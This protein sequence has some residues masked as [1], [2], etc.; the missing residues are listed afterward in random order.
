MGTTYHITYFDKHQRNFKDNIDSLLRVVNHAINTYDSAS[1][2]SQF[3][4]SPRGIALKDIH[5]R[6]ILRAAVSVF[7]LSSGAFDPTVMPLV[8][9]WGF[10][11][12][13]SRTPNQAMIDSLRNFVGMEK[14]RITP[15]SLLKTDPRVQLD[16]GGI[17]QGYGADVITAFLKAKGIDNMLVELGG[18]GMVHGR[19][20]QRNKPWQI[21]ILDPNSTLDDQFF[22]AYIAVKDQ[23]FTTAGT[24]FNY[25]EINGKKYAHTIDPVSGYPADLPLL[26]VSVF[27]LDCTTADAWDTA[28]MVMGHEKAIRILHTSPDLDAILFYTT[29]KDGIAT[30]IT[31]R[32][33]KAVTLEH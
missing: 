11:P 19:N 22:R 25:R 6:T 16:F 31:P 13:R 1:L 10:G 7:T 30:Y 3:N 20:I 4:T 26:S 18:E 15:D 5:F 12:A 21:G 27:A 8:N 17:G 29:P 9:A 24:Y 28:F 23:S 32:I 2:V 33:R 14:V